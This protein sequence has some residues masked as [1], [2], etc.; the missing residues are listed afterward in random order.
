MRGKAMITTMTGP[1][2]TFWRPS[3][4]L[5]RKRGR[6]V[7]KE[8]RKRNSSR[9]RPGSASLAL[10][11]KR[12]VS[13]VR[14]LLQ[15]SSPCSSSSLPRLHY[16]SLTLPRP[17]SPEFRCRNPPVARHFFSCAESRA[18]VFCALSGAVFDELFSPWLRCQRE[19]V[20]TL[21]CM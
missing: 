6:E 8:G 12:S 7:Q 2:A 19:P 16:Q 13:L 18:F 20:C 15:A 1:K 4:Q 21:S 17:S 5:G 10:H 3:W 11:N 14:M 9:P